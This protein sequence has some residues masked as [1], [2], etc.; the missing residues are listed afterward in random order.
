METFGRCHSW[1]VAGCGCEWWCACRWLSPLSCRWSLIC[2]SLGTGLCGGVEACRFYR[3]EEWRGGSNSTRAWK[4]VYSC[5]SLA[6]LTRVLCFATHSSIV[7]ESA[8][9]PEDFAWVGGSNIRS[10]SR[11][12]LLSINSAGETP[13]DVFS[14]VFMILCTMDNCSKD[15]LSWTRMSKRIAFK[16]HTSWLAR[17]TIP[18]SPLEYAVYSNCSAPDMRST[19]A[20]PQL[21][22]SLA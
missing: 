13:V 20:L 19:V 11:M 22:V 1:K 10:V 3:L 5:S 6:T 16:W 21:K 18:F 14:T 8:N 17:S 9:W 12:L 2:P 4:S 7:S 15:H